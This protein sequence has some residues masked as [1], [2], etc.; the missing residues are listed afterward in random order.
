MKQLAFSIFHPYLK[1]GRKT[2]HSTRAFLYVYL[3]IENVRISD[4][5]EIENFDSTNY[6]EFAVECDCN[7]KISQIRT[8]L[9][10]L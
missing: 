10:F 1:Y 2:I 7:R 6:S 4:D 8:T 5:S 9:G 3:P